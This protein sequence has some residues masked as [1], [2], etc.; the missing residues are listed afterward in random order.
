[1]T[2]NKWYSYNFSHILLFQRI[3][4]GER[5]SG[6]SC[7]FFTLKGRTETGTGDEWLHELDL[8]GRYVNIKKEQKF[9]LEFIDVYQRLLT[10]TT[11]IEIMQF[12]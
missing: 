5:S 9:V 12:E 7:G 3:C 1:M 2:K 6:K 11:N 8:Q 4:E 10:Q